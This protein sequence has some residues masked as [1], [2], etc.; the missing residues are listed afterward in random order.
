[1]TYLIQQLVADNV[2]R[3]WEPCPEFEE[4]ETKEL[5][6]AE[7]TQALLEVKDYEESEDYVYRVSVA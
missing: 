6:E 2:S 3:F 5:A 1:M 4:F 7:I